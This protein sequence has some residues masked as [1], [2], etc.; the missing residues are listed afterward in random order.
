MAHFAEVIEGVVHRVLVVG[1][2]NITDENGVEQEH[3]GLQW[4]PPTEGAWIQTSY[5]HNF[6]GTYAGIGYRYDAEQ[7][8]FIAPPL[9][10]G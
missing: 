3:L 2:Q 7:D 10:A 4:L 9:D 5:N 1:N 8:V 6:R